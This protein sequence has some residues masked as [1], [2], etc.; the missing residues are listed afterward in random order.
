MTIAEISMTDS[1]GIVVI[2][3]NFQR[4]DKPALPADISTQMI[5]SIDGSFF[6]DIFLHPD[7]GRPVMVF[8]HDIR[9][10]DLDTR[11]QT[12]TSIGAVITVVEMEKTIYNFLG[13][14]PELGD[15]AEA[16]I[17]RRTDQGVVFLSRLRFLENAPLNLTAGLDSPI[18]EAA[19][20]AALGAANAF[21]SK[22]Y[23]GQPVIA[24]YRQIE[25]AG[26]G[27]V[28]K[29]SQ[30]E[31]FAPIYDLARR[32]IQL[33]ALVLLGTVLLAI[34]LAPTLTR[35]IGA[36]V[37]ATQAI[38][39]GDLGVSL[40]TARTDEL[41]ALSASFQQMVDALKERRG[42]TERLTDM[43][44]RHA[45]E[46]EAAYSDLLRS[47][48]LKDAFIRNITHELR[49]PIAILSGFTELLLD[50]VDEFTVD[51]QEMLEA[52]ASQSQQVTQLVNDVVA[53]HN[54]ASDSHERRPLRMVDIARA[55]LEAYRLRS[56]SR[57][58]EGPYQFDFYCNEQEIEV[59][60]HPSQISRV[61]DSLLNNA[62]KF[63]PAGG[64]IS[65]QLR[66]IK[67]IDE[68]GQLVDWQI[69]SVMDEGI[70]INE[71]DLPH[72]WKRFFQA[73][74]GPTRRYGGTGLGLALVKEVVEAH[75]G[76]VWVDSLLGEG[77]T[78]S[79][80]LPVYRIVEPIALNI[81]DLSPV[82]VYQ[83]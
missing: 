31:A 66:H 49:T 60:V 74:Y 36:L 73:D 52:I 13:P 83:N 2:G 41:G 72:I 38:A 11:K 80:S 37:K 45:D 67:K 21:R 76:Q 82:Q 9:A 71:E 34:A 70:G 15:S 58:D 78:I 57:N 35:P 6:Y 63:S 30:V 25:P 14:I 77:T 61:F 64:M 54:M 19:R 55:S 29:Q 20:R 23:S 33:T 51:Q 39:G 17:V 18:A 7:T 32:I 16:L 62:V 46:L 4:V 50:D 59:N 69:V 26:W 5:P 24:A 79:F 40:H 28:V 1:E 68:S 53:L 12:G 27:L 22:D 42:E 48:Q 10:I 47:D 81:N 65:V 8:G 56:K 75:G 44:Q 3:T 43:L